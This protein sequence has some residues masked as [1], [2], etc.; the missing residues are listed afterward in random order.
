MD[1]K[2]TDNYHVIFISQYL[3]D[4][5]LCDKNLKWGILW[6]AYKLDDKNFPVILLQHIYLILTSILFGLIPFI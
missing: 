5:H 2:T 3:D 6:H 4:T 1:L